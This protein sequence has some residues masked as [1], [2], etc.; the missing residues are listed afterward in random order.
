[1]K[2]KLIDKIKNKKGEANL[3]FVFT[4]IFFFWM[5]LFMIDIF[6]LTYVYL[7]AVSVVRRV[8]EVVSTQGGVSPTTPVNYPTPSSYI[9]SENMKDYVYK[10]MSRNKVVEGDITITNKST[11]ESIVLNDANKN[12]VIDYGDEIGVELRYGFDFESMPDIIDKKMVFK[13][14]RVGSSQYKTR[15]SD[16]AGETIE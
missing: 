13:I 10:T 14:T 8:T 4:M 7:D 11:G 3:T 9:N 2:K 12:I 1:M 5:V 16:W 6:R 15:T